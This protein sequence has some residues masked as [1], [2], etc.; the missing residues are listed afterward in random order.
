[1]E[2]RFL[3]DWV[4]LHKE[5]FVAKYLAALFVVYLLESGIHGIGRHFPM[6]PMNVE[7]P[8][9]SVSL[10]QWHYCRYSQLLFSLG[11]ASSVPKL[12]HY[13]VV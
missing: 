11:P 5:L 8:I 12:T 6:Y 4:Y 13:G 9:S 1:M 3:L 7:H 2:I 10:C